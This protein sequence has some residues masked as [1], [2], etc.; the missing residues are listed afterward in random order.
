MSNESFGK[1]A[2]DA[3]RAATAGRYVLHTLANATRIS[4]EADA[5]T[6]AGAFSGVPAI[7]ACAGPS[8]DR[9]IHDIAHVRD[10]ALVIGCDTA[11]RPLTHAGVEPHLVVAIDGSQ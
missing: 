9:N 10:R 5:R 7:I 4:R 6:L 2:N 3:A 11:A 8:L 1:S